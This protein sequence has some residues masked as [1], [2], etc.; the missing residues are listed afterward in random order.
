M[1]DPPGTNSERSV[2]RSVGLTFQRPVTA[3]VQHSKPRHPQQ[4]TVQSI[5][6][7]VQVLRT[8]PDLRDLSLLKRHTLPDVALAPPFQPYTQ[9]KLL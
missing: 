9:R 2:V 5:Q 1:Q 4:Q 8:P 7:P 6:V 3:Q